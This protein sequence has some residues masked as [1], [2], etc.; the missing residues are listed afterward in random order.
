M[1]R[2]GTWWLLASALALCVACEDA[3]SGS[4]TASI[5][6]PAGDTSAD[7]PGD[8]GME[9]KTD[10]PAPD[11]VEPTPDVA[12]DLPPDLPSD[13]RPDAPPDVPADAGG[14]LP[15]DVPVD[16]PADT[17]AD[18]TVPPGCCLTDADCGLLAAPVAQ[19]CAEPAWG[20]DAVTG[21][22]KPVAKE[23][24]CWR[25]ADCPA[26]KVCHGA[27]ICPC[28]V[29]CDM[30]YEG[31][32]LC[33]QQDS[34]C[35]TLDPS[36]IG[37]WCDA[38]NLVLWNGTECVETC[39]GCCA[40]EPFCDLT[41]QSIAECQAACVKKPCDAQPELTP[42]QL[43]AEFPGDGTPGA[44][45][46][47]SDDAEILSIGEP[48]PDVG[49]GGKQI[50]FRL[51]DATLF[52]LQ[53]E[54]PAGLAP[55]L[56]EGDLVHLYAKRFWPWW[57]DFVVVVWPTYGGWPLFFAEAAAQSSPW[58][59]CDG[60]TYCPSSTFLPS[61]CE[62]FEMTC[63]EGVQ[64]PVQ[65]LA[66]GEITASEWGAV[67]RQGEIVDGYPGY[68]YG[69]ATAY[70][71]TDYQCADYPTPWN[72]SFLVRTYDAWKMAFDQDNPA[73]FE[74]YELC[75]KKD[76]ADLEATVQAVDPTLYCGVAGVFAGC[77]ELDE[78]GCH[79]DLEFVG[80]TKV[81]TPAKWAELKALSLLDIVARIGGGYWL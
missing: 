75:V 19:V 33:V 23:G 48:D 1:H 3:G 25:D 13:V 14:D 41:F 80:D 36:W 6:A 30:S 77:H 15:A 52:K 78:V 9:V 74:F 79:G 68:T 65:L 59:D 28:N 76:A 72:A 34:T 71:L 54:L 18:V 8:V 51:P 35:T 42:F 64:P 49:S 46:T 63:G 66:A 22:C 20:G 31:P 61:D 73:K 38:A 53:V 17:P 26:G 2:H 62:P 40:C 69:V 32:G 60:T 5:D 39:P 11:A 7:L 56:H 81:L 10:V 67:L 50:T 70:D 45:D 16:A 47:V 27:A 4:D 58:Y 29:D 55:P 24:W 57:V 12:P 43:W 44:D 21:V 37:E